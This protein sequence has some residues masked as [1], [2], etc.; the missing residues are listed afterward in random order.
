MNAKELTQQLTLDEKL[1][2][3]SGKDFWHLEGVERLELPSIMVT[4]GPHGLRKQM[5][6]G[7]HIGLSESVPATCYPTASLLAST[8]DV[9]LIERLGETLAIESKSEQVSVLLGPGANIKR[10][11]LC[12]RNFEYFSEDPV[13]SGKLA[14]AWIK[15]L[16]KD[17]IGASLKHFA[18]NNQETKRMTIDAIVDERTLREIYLKSFEI[19]IKEAKPWT[20]MASYNLINGTYATE[21]NW[22]INQVLRNE[23]K[24][25]GLVVTDWG[26]CNDRVKGLKA[27]LDLEMPGSHGAHT[28]EIKEAIKHSNLYMNELDS[29]VEKIIEL[30]LK[31]KAALGKEPKPFDIEK[32]HQFARQVASEGIVLL[33]N[34]HTILP[35][36]DDQK[37]A[38]IGRFAKEPRYQ[39]NG[40]SLIKPTKIETFYDAMTLRYPSQI[41][42]TDGYSLLDDNINEAMIDEALRVAKDSNVILLM[43]GLTEDYESEGFD[44]K[45]LSLPKNH[46][47][48][49]EAI[50]EAH[51]N[52]VVCL[53]N[54]APVLMP[55]KDKVSAIVEGYL[56][57][58]ASG[59]ALADILSGDV[60]PSGRLAET[61]PNS[62]EEIPA[63]LNFPRDSKQVIYQEGLYVGYR[64]YDSL[65]I[66]PLYSFGYGLSYTK[67]L[68]E[69]LSIT[70]SEE[71]VKIKLTV[72]NIGN[73]DGKEVVQVYFSKENSLIYRPLQELK[74]FKKINLKI[75]EKKEVEFS[76]L[77][78]DLKIFQDGFKL[79]S[80]SYQIRVGSSSQDIKLQEIIDISSKD[81]VKKDHLLAYR[82]SNKPFQPSK[83]DF[84]KL[85]GEP[86]PKSRAVKPYTLNSTLEEIKDTL[87]GKMIYRMVKKEYHSIAGDNPSKAMRDMLEISIQEMPLRSLV[88]FSDGKLS[89]KRANGM[90]DLLNKKRFKGFIK[91]LFG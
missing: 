30:I 64:A 81:K 14:S 60:N 51:S 62:L 77:L 84:E 57:G 63:S 43:V 48:L 35:L 27:G 87:I 4:D 28:K 22:L 78:D 32:H 80:G 5:I 59:V 33:K 12:G 16:Q 65:S 82:T 8:W 25:D 18:V 50:T 86:I 41:L 17:Q 66:K 90:I 45:H 11:P 46:E 23:W 15:G 69:N 85:Y 47:K 21:H 20:V 58:Q 42:Y 3:I 26:A 74:A 6:K 7:E 91:L 34:E 36:N 19:A 73:F 83:E 52:V 40:S 89:K 88:L 9:D 54:G 29:R 37:I 56:G 76:I 13:L 49:I 70:V 67:F 31:A 55:W 72:Q 44:R 1:K 53:S 75:G 68:Y 10:S 39:G 71:D 61:F 24:F 38:I 79:E 2:L